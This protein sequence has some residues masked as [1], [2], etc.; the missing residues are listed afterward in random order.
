MPVAKRDYYEVL[1]IE[2]GATADQIKQAFRRL[3]M[4]HHPDRNPSNK[5]EA[6]ERFKEISEAY[7]VL[8]DSQKRAAYDQYGHSGV[9]GA[10]RH[11]N[12]SW[13]DFTHFEDVSDLFG[14]LEDLLST[15]GLGDLFGGRVRGRRGAHR[16]GVAGADLEVPLEVDLNDVLTG[17][18]Q[19]LTI[20]RREVCEECRGE[21]SRGGTQR[22]TCPD[23]Q[24]QGQVRYSQGFFTMATTCGRCRGEGKIVKEA[25]P[26]C[27]GEGR[28]AA[29]RNLTVKVPP[30]VE[31]GMRLRVTGEGEAGVRGGGR[32][33]LY[34]LIQVKPHTFFHREGNHL[35][36]E[37]PV[38]M[39]Q[40]TLGTELKVPT[41]NGTVTMKV[42]PGTQ[43]GELFR[44]RGKGLPSLSGGERGD[45]LVRLTVEIPKRVTPAQRRLLEEFA[46]GSDQEGVFP[47]IQKFWEQVRGWMKS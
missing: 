39:I 32:G 19:R 25:C 31:T 3:A 26:S 20:R 29:E 35:F 40:A 45:Q 7:E 34:V 2:R 28:R 46:Q 42:P 37:V 36:C 15:F 4:K 44:L 17:K 30:G 9:E 12:F 13:E 43:P 27:R 21:G 22:L 41:L 8:S 18:E 5:K 24:G 16:A 23:C 1:G 33:D 14:G 11:G 10:F 38:D 6:E 47:T